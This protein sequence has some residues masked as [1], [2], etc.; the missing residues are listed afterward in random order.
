MYA[1]RIPELHSLSRLQENPWFQLNIDQELLQVVQFEDNITEAEW[2]PQDDLDS[3]GTMEIV[4]NLFQASET[5]IYSISQLGTRV[6]C[7]LYKLTESGNHE[8]AQ[9]TRVAG[10][11]IDIPI[12]WGDQDLYLA[13]RAGGGASSVAATLKHLPSRYGWKTSPSFLAIDFEIDCGYDGADGIRHI[14]G[15]SRELNVE[16]HTR[17]M[18]GRSK[19]SDFVLERPNIGTMFFDGFRGTVVVLSKDHKEAHIFSYARS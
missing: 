13:F 12:G 9:F 1:I 2:D 5:A 16:S 6:C 7:S 4:C 14:K 17:N 3:A 10:G 15:S 11:F 18:W 8:G 19:G